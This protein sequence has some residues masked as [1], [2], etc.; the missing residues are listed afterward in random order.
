MIKEAIN[1]LELNNTVDQTQQMNEES[2][3]VQNY[4]SELKN[5]EV[6]NIA[7][8]S[9]ISDQTK[10]S[11]I[12]ERE[13]KLT[14]NTLNTSNQRC[15]ETVFACVHSKSNIVKDDVKI[16]SNDQAE[17]IIAKHTNPLVPQKIALHQLDRS[18][19]FFGKTLGEGSYARVVHSK[20][21]TEKSPEFAIKIMEKAHMKKENKVKFVMIE[22]KILSM[23]N[24]PFVVKLYYT[25]QDVE[26][27]FFVLDYV[28]SGELL[29][30]IHKCYR[31]NKEK[32]L[33]H[34]AC[35]L[36]TTRFY[37]AEIVEALEYLHSK[38]VVHMDLK[39]ENILLTVEGHIK[40]VDFGTALLIADYKSPTE[41]SRESSYEP[42]FVGTAEYVS[43]EIL[44]EEA[45]SHSCDLWALGCI[46]YKMLY[47]VT[48]FYAENEYLI[49][50]NI[51]GHIDKSQPI[52]FYSNTLG[53][54]NLVV[55]REL[56]ESLLSA[57]P[58]DRIGATSYQE[59]KK[60]S[61]FEGIPWGQLEGSTTP[62][63]QMGHFQNTSNQSVW[64]DGGSEDWLLEIEEATSIPLEAEDPQ[65]TTIT[66]EKAASIFSS[67]SLQS[68]SDRS[69]SSMTTKV[70]STELLLRFMRPGESIVFTGYVSKRVGLFSK[71]R[72]MILT[73]TPRLLYVDRD[74]MELK[75]EIPWTAQHPVKFIKITKDTFDIL[76]TKSN[77]AYHFTDTRDA[78]C[79]VWADMIAAMQTKMD[80]NHHSARDPIPEETPSPLL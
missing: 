45:C 39:P 66:R 17:I 68:S 5:E 72:Q 19:F 18:Y 21:K 37:I 26:S 22:K 11:L 53:D 70:L 7:A 50:Q 78:G 24:H 49:F 75:G 55:V 65:N 30:L 34:T 52:T 38:G 23:L 16:I 51:N 25:F 76:C 74:A 56:I 71:N 20:M 13:N 4:L 47:G 64:R 10:E 48:P 60:H 46:T 67:F 69:G 41:D 58:S 77:R 29:G 1:K 35:D 62:A 57:S 36:I 43:P 15:D 59:L 54:E 8:I 2:A 40:V 14:D 44:N 28:A 80:E 3:S 6:E 27:L 73:D 12:D 79:Q 63:Y 9:S 61:F 42:L 31:Q 32:G 33:R